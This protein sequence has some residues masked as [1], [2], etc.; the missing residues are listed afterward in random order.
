MNS[1][2]ELNELIAEFDQEL[3][4][5]YANPKRQGCPG[6]AALKK[7]AMEPER[8]HAKAMIAH[9]SHCAPCLDE[10]K[11][12]RQATNKRRVAGRRSTL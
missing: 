7:L 8:F 11:T 1:Q 3:H 10:L 2:R 9:L 4:T 12:L 5:K 6:K